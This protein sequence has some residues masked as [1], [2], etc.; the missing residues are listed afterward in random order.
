MNIINTR[1]QHY[2]DINKGQGN[3]H[4]IAGMWSTFLGIEI[5]EHEAAWMMV[6]LKASRSKQDPH[7]TD[8]YLDAHGYIDIAEQLQ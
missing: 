4:R 7:H 2:G 3:M 1:A 5:T 6:L 8:D